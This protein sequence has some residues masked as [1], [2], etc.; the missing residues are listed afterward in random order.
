MKN[1]IIYIIISCMSV[2]YIGCKEEGRLDHIDYN[3]PAPAQVTDV[4]VRSTPGGAVLKYTL[5]KDENLR[6]VRAEY[7]IQPGVMQEC[8]SSQYEDSLVLQ[9][10]GE[11]RGYDV[12]LYSVGKNEKTSNPVQVKVNPDKA[13]VHL[14]TKQLKTAFGGV[15]I[16]IENPMKS[17]LAIEL[18][19]DTAH[20]GYQTLLTTFYTSLEKASFTFRGLDTIPSDFSVQLRDRW[21]NRSDVVEAK[22]TPMFEELIPKASWAGISLPTDDPFEPP[23]PLSALWDGVSSVNNWA[24]IARAGA[25]LKAL[26]LWWT[27]DMKQTV[28]LSRLK[29]WQH[30]NYL[31][32]SCSLSEFELY[33]SM[34]PNPNG[35]W[36]ASWI[37]LGKVKAVKPSGGALGVPGTAEDIAFLRAGIDYEFEECDFAPN[38]QV[39]VRYIRLKAL[40]S[41]RGYQSMNDEIWIAEISL[42]GA[43]QK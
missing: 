1:R 29:F 22:L 43:I 32:Q 9:G 3:A 7:E 11:I 13:P 2:F 17:A 18:M 16:K 34:N 28:V 31:W 24:N 26:P 39:P 5:P 40:N 23:G 4:I 35:S 33:G 38:P 8:K 20:L 15:T 21:N 37:P 41:S 12:K 10:F 27:W 36:D 25:G 42:W 6:Y 30:P 14:A 19:G